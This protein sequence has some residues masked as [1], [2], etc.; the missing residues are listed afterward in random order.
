MDREEFLRGYQKGEHAIFSV[1]TKLSKDRSNIKFYLFMLMLGDYI[2]L[3]D[4][5]DELREYAQLAMGPDFSTEPESFNKACYR[6]NFRGAKHLRSRR[7]KRMVD[8][9]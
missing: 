4:T 9:T 6:V 8:K 5:V 2:E 1:G 3:F 7:S